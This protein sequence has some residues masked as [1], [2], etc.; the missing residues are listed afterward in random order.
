MQTC[1][2]LFNMEQQEVDI[3][4][5]LTFMCILDRDRKVHTPSAASRID[6]RFGIE[7]ALSIFTITC[8]SADFPAIPQHAIQFQL[9]HFRSSQKEHLNYFYVFNG[10]ATKYDPNA[11]PA[12]NICRGLLARTR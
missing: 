1:P 7:S 9:Q 8:M 10:L 6:C 3:A 5:N 11:E 12:A 2:I 4:D